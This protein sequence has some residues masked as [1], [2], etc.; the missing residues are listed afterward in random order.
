[1]SQKLRQEYLFSSRFRLSQSSIS[2]MRRRSGGDP[3][4]LFTS[5]LTRIAIPHLSAILMPRSLKSSD[6]CNCWS[7]DLALPE[8]NL[9]ISAIAVYSVGKGRRPSIPPTSLTFASLLLIPSKEKLIDY[10]IP[11]LVAECQ[12]ER[13][14]GKV[15]VM[16][17]DDW[18]SPMLHFPRFSLCFCRA[19]D[20]K[21]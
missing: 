14:I 17:L 1:M 4:L 19:R 13:R 15:G 6:S 20:Q 5:L 9:F 10:L 7:I 3:R 12:S 18:P 2:T 16:R 21:R 8:R 11:A